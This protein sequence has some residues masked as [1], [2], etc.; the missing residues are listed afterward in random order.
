MSDTL[1]TVFIIFQIAVD[2]YVASIVIYWAVQRR[3]Y[4]TFNPL[5]PS[6]H[7]D[8]QMARQ[9][10]QEFRAISQ[11]SAELI[12]E[13]HKTHVPDPVEHHK[14]SPIVRSEPTEAPTRTPRPIAAP[15]TPDRFQRIAT[16]LRE[17]VP[18]A[19]IR[20]ATGA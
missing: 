13:L 1:V 2:V 8:L 3:R 17:G 16:L 15:A 11:K 6:Q 19:Q 7:R 18:H 5:S 10:L 12:T 14:T 4:G 20:H 9:V